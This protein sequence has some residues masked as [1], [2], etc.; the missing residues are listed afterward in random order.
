MSLLKYGDGV[1]SMP[2][3]KRGEK[4]AKIMTISNGV[5]RIRG[6]RC[7]YQLHMSLLLQTP[8]A[9]QTALIKLP[10]RSL[11]SSLPIIPIPGIIQR[12]PKYVRASKRVSPILKSAS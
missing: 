12:L 1:P 8:H 6:I 5:N 4:T 7:C 10:Q 2:R 11:L 9:Q 3:N